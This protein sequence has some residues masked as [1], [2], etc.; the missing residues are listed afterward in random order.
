MGRDVSCLGGT[1]RTARCAGV[2]SCS[3]LWV[4][5]ERE[6]ER[7]GSA[8]RGRAVGK[9]MSARDRSP[10]RARRLHLQTKRLHHQ[11]ERRVRNRGS[12]STEAFRIGGQSTI[13]WVQ[14]RSTIECVCVYTFRSG[15]AKKGH[16]SDFNDTFLFFTLWRGGGVV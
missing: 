16:G 3:I 11:M 2:L 9:Q 12:P 7:D 8:V 13:G 1:Q 6:R 10:T 15:V 5:R 4:V 14:G